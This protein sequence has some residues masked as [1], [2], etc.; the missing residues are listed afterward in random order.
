MAVFNSRAFVLFKAKKVKLKSAWKE[1]KKTFAI[2]YLAK[3]QHHFNN[4]LPGNLCPKE[5]K[6]DKLPGL[7]TENFTGFNSE[8]TFI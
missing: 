8:L 1:I 4:A 7:I 5:K 2:S 3:H 6:T